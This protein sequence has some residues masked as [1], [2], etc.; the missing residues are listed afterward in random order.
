M[1]HPVEEF[2]DYIWLTFGTHHYI[3]T[4]GV[5]DVVARLSANI[6]HIHLSSPIS[7][8]RADTENPALANIHCATPDGTQT[9]AGFHH[10]V[11]GTQANA[12]VPIL[13]S[14]LASLPLKSAQRRRVER[15][16]RTLAAFEYRPTIVIN[17]TDGSLMPDAARDRR[18]LNLVCLDPRSSHP[19]PAA[20]LDTCLPPSYTM[21]THVQRPPPSY[22]HPEQLPTLYQTTNPIVAP[23]ADTVLSVTR[24]ERAV[25]TR[26]GKAALPG[27][28]RAAGRKW[29]E[30]AVE[31]A[32]RS[33]VGPLQGRGVEGAGEPAVGVWVCG[34]YAYPG[35]PLLE[36]CV[37]SAQN[38]AR[39]IVALESGSKGEDAA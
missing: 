24:L 32:A 39:A 23:R 6:P 31:A 11:F 8:I 18:D 37:V 16:G 1:E 21:A 36:G 2:L 38:V 34:S 25:L 26:A 14:Y 27:L 3:V 5:R 10:I 15:L 35:I 7:A 12:A 19:D 13:S 9:H 17:H 30:S 33:G 4:S 28:Y 22:A 29:W 20:P